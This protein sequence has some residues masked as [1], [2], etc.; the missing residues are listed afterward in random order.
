MKMPNGI[1]VFEKDEALPKLPDGL[2][3]NYAEDV[4]SPYG[5]KISIV[6]NKATWVRATKED[7]TAS[8]MQRLGVPASDVKGNSCSQTGPRSCDFGPCW[9][10]GICKLIYNPALHYYYCGCA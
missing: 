8:E 7:Y 3:D 1:E 5:F 10:R 2:T 6:N 4:I 9:G